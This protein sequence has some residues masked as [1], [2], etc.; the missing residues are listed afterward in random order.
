VNLSAWY[1]FEGDPCDS[2][3]NGHDGVSLVDLTYSADSREGGLSIKLDG[4]DDYVVV[5]PVGISGNR[6]R[7]IAGW[8]KATKSATQIPGWTNVFGFSGEAI[9]N[10]HF[11]I[12]RSGASDHYC[13][14]V[15]GWYANIAPLDTEWHY[16]AATYD[17]ETIAWYHNGALMGTHDPPYLD[18]YDFVI[19]GKRI[20]G[21][22]LF[23]GLVDDVRIYNRALSHGE[24]T[25]LADSSID[26]FEINGHPYL[27]ALNNCCGQEIDSPG[28][29]PRPGEVYLKRIND[30]PCTGWE[31]VYQLEDMKI[32]RDRTVMDEDGPPAIMM[33]DFNI[34][35][36]KYGIM[37]E[38]FGKASAVDAYEQVADAIQ[39]GNTI[40]W[41][42]NKLMQYFWPHVDPA[43][44][45]LVDRIDYVYVK[46][47]GAGLELVPTGALVFRHWTYG[48]D[49]MELSDHYPL[50][51][52][53]SLEAGCPVR[54]KGDFNCDG[55]INFADFSILGSAWMSEPNDG[56]WDP[57]CDISELADNFIDTKDVDIFAR[58]W[59]KMPVY[60]V[61]QDKRYG[62]I[63]TAINDANDRDEIEVSPGTYYEA[64]DFKGK[65][66]T[67]YSTDGP[68]V[69]TINGTGYDHVVQCVS[70]EDA[71]TILEGFTITGGNANGSWP[72]NCGG[73]MYNERSN[74]TIINCIFTA[75][76]ADA[77]GGGMYNHVYNDQKYGNPTVVN[78]TFQNNIAGKG[79]GMCNDWHVDAQVTNCIFSNNSAIVDG[80]GIFNEHTSSPTVT[81]C[82]FTGNS[83]GFRGGGMYNDKSSNPTVVNCTFTWNNAAYYAAMV[84]NA[85]SNPTVTDCIF[86]LNGA[87][88]NGGAMA[89]FQSSPDVNHCT[90]S[91]NT[92]GGYGGGMINSA[93][94]PTVTD[95]NFTGNEASEAGGM[96]NDNSSPMVIN[97]AFT[98]NS[99]TGSIGGGMYNIGSSS[100]TVTNCTFTGNDANTYG[101]G[102]DNRVGSNPTVTN[103][104][105]S[106]NSAGSYGGGMYNYQSSP[107]LTNCILW[108]NTAPT[109]PQIHGDNP[110]VKY[111]DVQGGTG[112][113]WFG[114]GC[115]DAD[116]YFVDV[117]A[118]DFRLLSDSPCID[119]GDNSA[120]GLPTTD[121]AGN[122]RV[123][124]GIVDMGAYE[125]FTPPPPTSSV[126]N[127]EY[128]SIICA[129]WLGG[130]VSGL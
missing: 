25:E 97:C 22:A 102:M 89:N 114:L 31:N 29:R 55:L 40:D 73:G 10:W 74:P 67:L 38:L 1:Q 85:N 2:S 30:D 72:D 50:F 12:Q 104:T 106:G 17:G 68:S 18:T 41:N 80:G 119:A 111:S 107:T 95:C 11:D 109:G 91:D 63:Q 126:G 101:G 124:N 99:A 27:F 105:F 5:G 20:D 100:P 78:C 90:F 108:G 113:S 23:P 46:Q 28:C 19:I 71:N 83:S 26:V 61:T 88:N 127:F 15:F 47:S 42:S 110:T 45:D 49:D 122:P 87:I 118:N 76:S 21:A 84:N 60:N 36:G 103:C 128:L 13:I 112:Q 48:A 86:T 3:G 116:P 98:D 130:T 34:H 92:A 64:I 39:D 120:P 24:I 16:L 79:G 62:F 44:P 43:D 35:R 96:F 52:T 56:A 54:M 32:I 66:I 53:F 33:G 117:D 8:V 51:V 115:I 82:T 75:N 125:Y 123:W 93:S 9:D 65:A 129:N 14:H 7:T 77:N 37:D 6:S 69:T 59:L 4:V 94:N 121:I 81:D 70:Y 57:A 58:V